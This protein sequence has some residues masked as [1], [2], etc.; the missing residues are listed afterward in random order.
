MITNFIKLNNESQKT[1]YKIIKNDTFPM[2][3]TDKYYDRSQIETLIEYGYLKKITEVETF[4]VIGGWH[5]WVVP[6]YEG[7]NY[8][9][10]KREFYL[11]KVIDDLKFLLPFVISIIALFK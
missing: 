3:L 8:K 9:T 5:C 6:T 1:L 7:K 11:D 2:E 4:D 10:I